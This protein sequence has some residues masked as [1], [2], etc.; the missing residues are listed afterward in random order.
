MATNTYELI[1]K[2]GL[3]YRFDTEK[4]ALLKGLQYQSHSPVKFLFLRHYGQ[5]YDEIRF[6]YDSQR[7]GDF[8]PVCEKA[9][10]LLAFEELKRVVKN[11]EVLELFGQ[12][13]KIYK[14]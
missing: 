2:N 8:N 11:A 10:V 14:S 12:I 7:D 5:K 4:E 9:L 6:L 13:E 3:A 1:L